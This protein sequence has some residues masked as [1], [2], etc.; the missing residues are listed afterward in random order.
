MVG[1]TLAQRT[2]EAFGQAFG[3]DRAPQVFVAPGRINLIGEHTDYNEGLV[4]PAAIDRYTAVALRLRADGQANFTSPLDGRTHRC[5]TL[6]SQ[7]TG[8]WIDYAIGVAQQLRGRGV[9]IRGFDCAVQSDVPVGAGLASSAALTVALA[10]GLLELAGAQLRPAELIEAC[11]AAENTFVAVPTGVM[12]QY[13]VVRGRTGHAL[14]LDCRSLQAEA[15]PLPPADFEW[16]LCHSMVKH[17]LAASAYAERRAEC[18]QAVRL[19]QQ[20]LPDLKALRD[21]DAQALQ[22]YEHALPLHL[23]HRVSHVVAENER[24]ERAAEALR[25]QAYDQLGELMYASHRSLSAQYQVSCEELDLLVHLASLQP[26]TLGAR[27]MGG[28]FGGCTLNLVASD[29]V[30]PFVREVPRAYRQRTGI[31]TGILIVR[32][33]DGALPLPV[34]VRSVA[35]QES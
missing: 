14:F 6:P 4:L 20:R 30:A 21:L 28:G 26:G 9:P 10:R 17:E 24:A 2:I 18:Q 23:F 8:L 16:V 13:A 31:D 34:R 3:A 5:R 22:A 35:Q 11:R 29:R 1:G 7:R 12:D 19:L 27:M 33:V 32:T 25:T 15:L